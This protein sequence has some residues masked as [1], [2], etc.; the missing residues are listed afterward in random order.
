MNNTAKISASI[1]IDDPEAM[2]AK[3]CSIAGRQAPQFVAGRRIMFEI[4]SVCSLC[5]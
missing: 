1:G 5:D 2:F 4:E 3:H